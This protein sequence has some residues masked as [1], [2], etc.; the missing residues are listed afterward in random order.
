LLI[1][2]LNYE[3]QDEF[4]HTILD[5]INSIKAEVARAK[6]EECEQAL[7]ALAA[8]KDEEFKQIIEKVFHEHYVDPWISN[9][10]KDLLK[11]LGR[12]EE[13]AEERQ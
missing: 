7:S 6:D 10:Y 11:E 2:F 5:I 13:K 12:G 8:A 4:V 9:I 1:G 3:N